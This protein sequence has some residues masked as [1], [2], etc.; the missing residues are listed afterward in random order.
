MR[1]VRHYE[2]G[3]PSVLTVENAPP[4]LP[5]P[6]DLL[7]RTTAIGVTLPAVRR[8]RAGDPAALP[9]P[10]GG[11]VA[12]EVIGTGPGDTGGFTPGDRVTGLSFT[13]SYAEI[14]TV[15]A[16]LATRIPPWASDTLA[17]ALVRSGH[18]AL[19]VLATAGLHPADPPPPSTE[20]PGT[21]LSAT[22][23]T[24][25]EPAPHDEAAPPARPATQPV[26]PTG[27]TAPPPAGS[28]LVTGAASGVGH[29]LVQ[30]AKLSG[31]PRVVAAA[32]DPA[33]AG[34]LRA[35]GADEV[36]TYDG[37]EWG[38]PVDVAFDAV[39]GE[40]LP[41]ALGAVRAGGRLVFLGSGGGTVAAHELLAGGKT[42]TGF[43]MARFAATRPEEYR[44]HG[45]R[46]WELAHSG[47][48][49][50]VVHVELP[51]AGAAEAHRIVESRANL[52][53]I[54]LRP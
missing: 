44:R 37:A 20:T 6:G 38:A 28:V 40:V 3:D 15:P 41:R 36:V 10:I 53:K 46:L 21:G 5:G 13:G 18:V 49:R 1:R 19:G 35:L 34:F 52:G 27:G 9:A 12:G 23:A 39:G 47:R 51:L 54:V 8:V 43:T 45:R 32:G 14:V 24:S 2:Y 17:V 48:L 29:L 31:V 7:V 11:E 4:P 26:P 33:K 42:I 16:T 22:A 50:P 25:G 30:L